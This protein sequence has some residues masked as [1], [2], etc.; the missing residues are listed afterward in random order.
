MRWTGRRLP[1]GAIHCGPCPS[2]R[3]PTPASASSIDPPSRSRRTCRSPRCSSASSRP[4]ARSNAASVAV[5]LA[6]AS[7]RCRSASDRVGSP[8][9]ARV[10]LTWTT[11]QRAVVRSS[12]DETRVGTNIRLGTCG[13]PTVTTASPACVASAAEDGG[14]GTPTTSPGTGRTS[15]NPEIPDPRIRP[16]AY[17]IANA[18]FVPSQFWTL[19]SSTSPV[20]ASAASSGL[21]VPAR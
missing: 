3:S 16:S 18:S 6:I 5:E 11:V 12:V 17:V 20:I 19:C 13:P 21:A 14:P 4:R 9:G 10:A 2:A 8:N 1:P 7:D 15:L